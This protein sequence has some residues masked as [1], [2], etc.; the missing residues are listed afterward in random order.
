MNGQL[1]QTCKK[2]QSM[3]WIA[4]YLVT[5]HQHLKVTSLMSLALESNGT[6]IA[7]FIP[8]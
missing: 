5:L 8:N 7:A 3:K 4:M 2:T 6:E 1:V